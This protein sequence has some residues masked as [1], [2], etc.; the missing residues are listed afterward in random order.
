MIFCKAF[1][2][3]TIFSIVQP[4]FPTPDTNY[5]VWKKYRKLFEIIKNSCSAN[6]TVNYLSFML[7]VSPS[8]LTK[9]F[10][11]DTGETLK[12]YLTKK[13]IQYSKEHLLLSDLSIKEIAYELKFNDEFYF[14]HF[15]KKHVGIS[16]KEYRIKNKI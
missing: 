14:S 3:N 15:F 1:I 6:I 8:T 12:S 16:P 13:L 7:G 11:K 4:Y 5:D 2:L 9:N 10:K